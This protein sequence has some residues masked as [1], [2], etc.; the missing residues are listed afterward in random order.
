MI[1]RTSLALLVLLSS[2]S[3]IGC[4]MDQKHPDVADMSWEEILA[5]A[6]GGTVQ[7]YGWGGA[8]NINQWLETTVANHLKDN[9]NISFKRV[10]MVPT[11]YIPKLLS[12]KQLESKGTIDILWINGENFFQAKSKGLLF[13]PFTDLMPHFNTYVDA[14]SPDTTY[15]FGHPVEGLE[16][17]YG[18]AQF[19][20]LGDTAKLKF[21][22][23]SHKELLE[24][25][26]IHPGRISYPE[27]SDFTG[28]AFVR[29]IIYDV[30]GHEPFIGLTTDKETLRSMIAPAMEYLRELKPYLWN[31]GETYPANS[32]QMDNLYADGEL[33]LTMNYTPF[34]AA[35][36]IAEGIFPKTTQTFLFDK[37]TI[38]NTHFL[39]IPF[40]APNKAAALVA[41]NAI[42]SP[43]I[44]LS[45]YDPA[46]WGDLPVTSPD[47]LTEEQRTAFSR[48]SLG[49]G[50]LGQEDLLTKRVPEMPAE[51]IVFVEE[52]WREEVL[53]Q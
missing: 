29:N 26:R 15:D 38:G 11:E 39:A 42:L 30:V 51:L 19:V 16:A 4:G 2:L 28:S 49:E 31:Q 45:K 46:V 48:V 5:T 33:W 20:L 44:Q 25:A 7:F 10:S 9:H 24:L 6:D 50:V 53:G 52:I 14:G 43:E 13:G 27:V 41:I 36:R 12:E 47:L 8:A 35:S 21:L 40:N 22:P 23:G 32:A 17:P 3:L 34:H 1:Y 37:G 18:K